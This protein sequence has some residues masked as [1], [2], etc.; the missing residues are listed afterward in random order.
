MRPL[1]NPMSGQM[2]GIQNLS[3]RDARPTEIRPSSFVQGI[4]QEEKISQEQLIYE[5][6]E[7]DDNLQMTFVGECFLGDLFVNFLE[8]L[9][10][11]S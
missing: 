6:V 10:I 5:S 4:P 11:L 3:P 9:H 1:P 8:I 7:S 2:I